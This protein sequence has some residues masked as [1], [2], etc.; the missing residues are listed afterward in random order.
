[1]DSVTTLKQEIPCYL[2]KEQIATACTN[3]PCNNGNESFA[4]GGL[5]N[6]CTALSEAMFLEELP[7]KYT[8]GKPFHLQ[9]CNSTRELKISKTPERSQVPNFDRKATASVS[10][11]GTTKA[12]VEH[13]GRSTSVQDVR[14]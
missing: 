1:M 7:I 4:C 6:Y 9:L 2:L 14:G 11:L 8:K 3:E 5:G 12:I 13:S 10:E